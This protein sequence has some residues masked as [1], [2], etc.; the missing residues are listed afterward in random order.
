MSAPFTANPNS[1]RNS[2]TSP[3]FIAVMPDSNADNEK[4]PPAD[5]ADAT[6]VLKA[7]TALIPLYTA[8]PAMIVTG[9][10]WRGG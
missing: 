7:C 9:K 5:P 10:V 1:P 3:D 8:N 6:A 2:T 4:L